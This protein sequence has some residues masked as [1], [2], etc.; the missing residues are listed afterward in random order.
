[1]TDAKCQ[2]S[3]GRLQDC[4]SHTP[5]KAARAPRTVHGRL[6]RPPPLG[7]C[8]WISPVAPADTTVQ[9]AV[10]HEYPLGQHPA[11]G[12]ASAPHRYQPDAQVLVGAGGGRPSVTGTTTVAPLVSTMVVSG[13]GGHDVVAQSRP[14]WQQPA[15][16]RARH[17]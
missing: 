14:V 1:M 13:V 3:E 15:P 6:A 4:R 8:F 17:G 5:E 16:A 9:L 12:P 11:T 7:N 2:I 10:P